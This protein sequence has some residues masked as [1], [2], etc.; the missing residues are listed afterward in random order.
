MS[1]SMGQSGLHRGAQLPYKVLAGVE[2]CP[3][4]WCVVSGKLQGITLFPQVPEVF[5]R[6]VDVLDYKPAFT[7]IALHMPIGLLSSPEAGARPCDREAR[8]LLGWPRA[9]A[10]SMAPTRAAVMAASYDE[11]RAANGGKLDAVTWKLMPKL[12]EVAAEIQPYWQRT[13]FE[14]N[15]ELIFYQLNDDQPL[16]YSKRYS[17]GVKER[18]A[19][20]ENKL[21]GA[22]RIFEE[23][24]PGVTERH[25]VDA[26]AD[27]WAARRIAARSVTRV[28]EM[29][30]WDDEG[31]RMEILR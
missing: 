24:V 8:A 30:E 5:P 18:R 14:V 26:L 29:P 17:I 3:G 6:F 10:V 4:G 11:A 7:V 9:A 20:L 1:M 22:E 28:P 12:R 21:Q 19:L 15:P 27:V 25:V 16:H 13:V 31:L 2:P 23:K